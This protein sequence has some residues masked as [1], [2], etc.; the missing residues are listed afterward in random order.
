MTNPDEQNQ[1][2]EILPTTEVPAVGW[3][4]PHLDKLPIEDTAVASP[5]DIADAGFLS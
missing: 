2:P 3:A 5:N 1:S 4:P